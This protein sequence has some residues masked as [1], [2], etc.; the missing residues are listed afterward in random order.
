MNPIHDTLMRHTVERGNGVILASVQLL[1]ATSL[2]GPYVEENREN[3]E[4]Q[5]LLK[6]VAA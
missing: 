6:T 5:V 1:A 2:C 4:E 3:D